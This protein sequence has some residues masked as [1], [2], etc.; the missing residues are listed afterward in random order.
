[1]Y[2]SGPSKV[3]EA[4]NEALLE[5]GLAAT[6]DKSQ[7]EEYIATYFSRFPRLKKWIDNSHA[8]IKNNGFIYNFFGRKRRLLNVNSKDRGIASGEIRSGF[9]A[10]IQSVS[11]DHLLLGAIEADNEITEKKLDATI[12][13]LVHDSVVAEVREDLVDEYLEILIRR[14]QTDRGCSIPGTPIG[15]EQDSEKGGSTDYSCGKLLKMFPDIAQ[16]L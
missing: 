12:F 9:N 4:V 3:A 13:A 15:V 8:Q 11:S 5:N 6:C 16:I 7:A 10:I 1:M 2:G 14:I